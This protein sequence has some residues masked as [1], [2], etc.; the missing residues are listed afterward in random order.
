MLFFGKKKQIADDKDNA[1]KRL[2]QRAV[3]YV[4]RR[5][6]ETYD[7][8]IIGRDGVVNILDDDLVIMC[9][10]EEV[11]RAKRLFCEA[12]ELMSLDGAV[13]KVIDDDGETIDTVIAYYKYYRK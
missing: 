10:A 7:E 3:K 1:V 8:T 4:T 6:S 2:D 13:I 9:G 11:F 12:A 5:N